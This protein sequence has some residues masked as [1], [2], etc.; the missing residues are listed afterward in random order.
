VGWTRQVQDRVIFRA[1]VGTA[2]NVRA[3][4]RSD[5]FLAE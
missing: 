1:Y 3:H 5:N 2:M 4:R